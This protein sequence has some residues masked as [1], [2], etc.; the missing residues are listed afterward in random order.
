MKYIHYKNNLNENI[1]NRVVDKTMNKLEKQIR[2]N[3]EDVLIE[4]LGWCLFRRMLN[5]TCYLD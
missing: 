3:K 4:M 2:I 5:N 1:F